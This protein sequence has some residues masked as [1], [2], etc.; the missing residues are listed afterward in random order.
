MGDILNRQ[1]TTEGYTTTLVQD[2]ALAL[3][4]IRSFGPDL[5]LLDI[6]LPN[7]SGYEILEAK[8]KDPTISPIPVIIISNS[9]QPVE[10]TR[11]LALGVKDYLVKAQFDPEEVLIKVKAQLRKTGEAFD[12][13]TS[14]EEAM[15]SNEEVVNLGGKK[16]LWVEARRSHVVLLFLFLHI[17]TLTFPD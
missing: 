2:G 1:L 5:I 3:E 6:I 10:I 16:I 4:K 11:A 9:G 17:D 15:D 8:L 13:A 12:V 7:M 14:L